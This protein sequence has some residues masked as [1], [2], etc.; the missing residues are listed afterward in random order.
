MGLMRGPLTICNTGPMLHHIPTITSI[1]SVRINNSH[2]RRGVPNRLTIIII[3]AGL[4][5]LSGV[6]SSISHQESLVLSSV[7]KLRVMNR[8]TGPM[9]RPMELILPTTLA[10]CLAGTSFNWQTIC[11]LH[12]TAVS[13]SRGTSI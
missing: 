1:T 6:T 8:L 5:K 3:Q 7:Y 13:L 11:S 2:C 4:P 10:N 12:A 9:A